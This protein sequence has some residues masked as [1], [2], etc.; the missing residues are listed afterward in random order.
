MGIFSSKVKFQDGT[1]YREVNRHGTLVRD[2]KKISGR[3]RKRLRKQFKMPYL[4][5][6]DLGL[7]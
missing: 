6:V 5:A 3:E 7:V 2:P 1:Q 4:R